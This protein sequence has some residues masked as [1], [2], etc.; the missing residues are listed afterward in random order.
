MDILQV[1]NLTKQF[2]LYKAVDN[3]TFSLK[4]GEILGMLGPNGAGK[5]TT[6]QMLLGV[7]TPTF[8]SISYFEKSLFN[9]KEEILEQVNFSSTYTKLPENLTVL[10]N[11]TF[12]SYLYDIKHRKDRIIKLADQFNLNNL[13]HMQCSDLSAG[14]MTRLTLAKAFINYPKVL[15]LDEPTASLDPDVADFIRKF[16]MEERKKFQVSIIIT[17]HNMAEVEEVC[18]RVIFI[19]QGRIIANDTPEGLAKTIDT[20]HVELLVKD[21][22]KRT[23]E[24]C[25]EK[26]MKYEIKGRYIVIDVKEENI[27]VLLYNLMEKG[28]YYDEI[29]IEK[30]TLED[31]FLQVVKQKHE[32][33]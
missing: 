24:I 15:L 22:L 28:V 26:G 19:D 7:L 10:E 20:S 3:I 29:A 33:P 8:G 30:P 27:P 12:I 25:H 4:E 11:L 23:I 31:Y 13:M 5:T 2:D 14:Q 18:D 9:H 1:A 6:I 17:S 16:L 32:S 21:G